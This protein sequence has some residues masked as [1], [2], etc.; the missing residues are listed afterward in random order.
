MHCLSVVL[1]LCLYHHL[2]SLRITK[3][4][5]TLIEAATFLGCK[6]WRLVEDCIP[7]IRH[8]YNDE[9]NQDKES[10]KKDNHNKDNHEKDIYQL[11][12]DFF[13]SRGILG[14]FGIGVNIYTLHM[15]D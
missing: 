7:K 3:P 11:K 13:L 10:N 15:I 12:Y 8:W 5:G 9:D 4:P 1:W 2:H 14:L 6:E